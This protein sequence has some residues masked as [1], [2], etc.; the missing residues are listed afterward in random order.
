MVNVDMFYLYVSMSVLREVGNQ[1]QYI[2]VNTQ[3]NVITIADL[4]CTN[5][6]KQQLARFRVLSAGT[7]QTHICNLRNLFS[8]L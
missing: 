8:V 1:C 7:D 2:A 5:I 4:Q 3:L 6:A